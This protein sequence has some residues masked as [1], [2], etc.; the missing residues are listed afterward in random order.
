[1][2]D[3]VS[4][5]EKGKWFDELLKL[6]EEVAKKKEKEFLGKTYRVLCDG[7]TDDGERMTGH[8]SGTAVI[9]FEGD[10]SLLGKFVNVRV[11]STHGALKGKII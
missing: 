6:Q 5:E 2:D 11:D 8:T 10:D 9:E 3:P 1:M 4:R 7:K